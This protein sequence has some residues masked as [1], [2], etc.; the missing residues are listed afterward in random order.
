LEALE[1]EI[2]ADID[3]LEV[4]AIQQERQEDY[5]DARSSHKNIGLAW[6]AF[7]RQK[8]VDIILSPEDVAMMMVLFKAMRESYKH[9]DDNVLDLKAYLDFYEQF[10]K[11]E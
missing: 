1:N 7:L 8:G 10:I 5:G 3:A 2:A 6:S 9:K 11:P 4:L